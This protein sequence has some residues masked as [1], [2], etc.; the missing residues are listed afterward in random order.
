[1]KSKGYGSAY[2]GLSDA[3]KEGTWTWV[4]DYSSTYRNWKSNEPNGGTYENYAMFY[5]K[6]TDKKWNDGDF[7]AGSTF[8]LNGKLIK[9]TNAFICEW[10]TVKSST[11]T[12]PV[13]PSGDVLKGTNGHDDLYN[14]SK[15]ASKVIYAYDGNDTVENDVKNV[16]IS[17]GKGNDYIHT[18]YNNNGSV[19]G[20]A[21]DDTII[22]YKGTHLTL[23]G[24]AGNDS[25]WGGVNSDTL[26]GGSGNDIFVY[27]LSQGT[28]Y[29][30]DFS[31]G[32]MLKI[33]KT[34]G[35]EGGTFTRGCW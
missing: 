19:S 17:G 23:N 3:V 12:V 27:K 33:L 22:A 5:Y 34:N 35:S 31:G 25:L 21:G 15:N 7:S 26:I 32:D 11:A 8:Y 10:D 1:M 2:F 9:D 16:Y 29:I 24:G 20:D 30:T 18:E 14:S 4:N 28:D 13:A 6:Y